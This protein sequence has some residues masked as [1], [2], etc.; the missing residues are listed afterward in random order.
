V[1]RALLAAG[2]FHREEHGKVRVR[3]RQRGVQ[4]SKA[5][6]LRLMRVHGLLAPHA[7]RT[8][9]AVAVRSFKATSAGT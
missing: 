7:P 8:V 3:L 1:I 5:R 6:V 2:A 9:V 4:I